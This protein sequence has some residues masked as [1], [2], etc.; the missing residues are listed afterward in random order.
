MRQEKKGLIFGQL[1]RPCDAEGQWVTLLGCPLGLGLT[2]TVPVQEK[3]SVLVPL[4]ENVI[5]DLQGETLEVTK[6]PSIQAPA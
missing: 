6:E 2:L 1:H 5:Q 3:G 4:G